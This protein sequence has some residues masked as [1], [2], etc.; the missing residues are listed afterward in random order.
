[1]RAERQHC[2]PEVE[3][4][5]SRDCRSQQWHRYLAMSL[6]VSAR[7]FLKSKSISLT[8]RQLARPVRTSCGMRIG[9]S[10]NYTLIDPTLTVSRSKVIL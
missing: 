9:H 2:R 10:K 8:L 3:Q 1:M 6:S 5:E 7:R 4:P